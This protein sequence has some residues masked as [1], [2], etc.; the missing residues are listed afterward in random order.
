MPFIASPATP[1][2][3]SQDV[4]LKSHILSF[5]ISISSCLYSALLFLG[6][7]LESVIQEPYA[8][9]LTFCLFAEELFSWEIIIFSY[10][11]SFFSPSV[12]VAFK[13]L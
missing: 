11:K 10:K 3:Q 8:A 5:M 4:A 2:C 7:D 9:T 6:L 1:F 13:F 12:C